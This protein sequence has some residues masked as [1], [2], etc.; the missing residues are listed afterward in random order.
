MKAALA[1]NAPYTL[2]NRDLDEIGLLESSC[3]TRGISHLGSE[4]GGGGRVTRDF[5]RIAEQ[6]SLNLLLHLGVLRSREKPMARRTRLLEVE[7]SQSYVVAPERGIFEPFFD[8][9][10]DVRVGDVV[11]QIHSIN[12]VDNKSC[13]A[14]ERARRHSPLQAPAWRGERGDNILIIARDVSEEDL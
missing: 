1:F 13:R 4:F 7:D 11:G 14:K 9:A 12:S 5:V 3:E 6:G 2:I 10:E 8:L